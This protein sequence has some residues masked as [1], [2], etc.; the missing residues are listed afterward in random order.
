MANRDGRGPLGQGP[1]SG[2]GRGRGKG[3]KIGGRGL[4]GSRECICPKC[5]YKEL[6]SRG[7]PCTEI[8]C[9]KCGTLMKGAFCS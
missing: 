2:R 6:H 1:M 4:G 7:I 9:P 5:K 3:R 8:K